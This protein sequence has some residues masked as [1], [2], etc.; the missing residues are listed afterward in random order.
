MSNDHP[1]SPDTDA[2]AKID[3]GEDAAEEVCALT[4]RAIRSVGEA[5]SVGIGLGQV[6]LV[7]PAASVD[8]AVDIGAIGSVTVREDPQRRCGKVAAML[9]SIGESVLADDIL[10]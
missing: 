1:D 2:P 8:Q 9:F 3:I 5:L 10:L 6:G 7:G 4:G